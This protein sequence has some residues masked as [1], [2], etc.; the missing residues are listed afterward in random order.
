MSKIDFSVQISKW[1]AI[2]LHRLFVAILAQ[3]SE[4]KC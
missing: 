1:K 3:I 2:E 4:G